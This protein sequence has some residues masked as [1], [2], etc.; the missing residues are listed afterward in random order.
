MVTLAGHCSELYLVIT[1][2]N[3]SRNL[4]MRVSY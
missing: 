3:D 1:D 2:E 4:E